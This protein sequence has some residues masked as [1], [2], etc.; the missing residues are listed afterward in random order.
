MQRT[1]PEP[2]MHFGCPD[3]EAWTVLDESVMRSHVGRNRERRDRRP[4]AWPSRSAAAYRRVAV[5]SPF[6]PIGRDAL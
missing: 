2:P 4:P 1:I 6:R 3:C 5:A